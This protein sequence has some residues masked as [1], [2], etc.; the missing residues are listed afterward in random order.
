MSTVIQA[1]AVAQKLPRSVLRHRPIQATTDIPEFVIL[2]P[3]ASQAKSPRAQ[4]TP[5][6]KAEIPATAPAPKRALHT[7]GEMKGAWLIYLVI[8]MLMMMLLLW[9]GQFVWNW[10]NTVVDD[11]RYGRPRTT[12]VDQFVGHETGK[13]PSHFVAL[14]L[15]GQVYVLEIPGGKASA[16]HLLVGPHL[17]GPGADLAPVSLSFPGNPHQ[18][19]LLITVDGIQTR[20]HNTGTA[21]TPTS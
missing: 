2:T 5:T 9:V 1:E 3:R 4:A 21:Y 14:N 17:I 16:S 10:G 18:P 8:G 15:D 20:F 13:T 19:D 12:N 11:V 7:W 6:P